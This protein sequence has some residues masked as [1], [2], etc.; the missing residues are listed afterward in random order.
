MVEKP[1]GKD[2]STFNELQREISKYFTE[3]ETYRIDHY[4]GKEMVQNIQVLR[5]A[6]AVFEPLWNKH[7]I[8]TIQ[9]TFKENIGTEGR[10]G[11][12]E[13]TGVIRDV[14]QNHLLQVLSLVAMEPPITLRADDVRDEKLRLLK[15]IAPVMPQ[16][17]VLG[18]YT[19]NA[20]GT[21]PGYTDEEGI[22]KDSNTA[23]YAA[24]VMRINNPRWKGVPFIIR[25]GKALNEKKAEIRIQF[26]A[27]P[28]S[29]FNWGTGLTGVPSTHA[30]LASCHSAPGT[31]GSLVEQAAGTVAHSEENA[32]QAALTEAQGEYPTQVMSAE[33]T[34][35]CHVLERPILG[36]GQNPPF[37]EYEG[38]TADK[39]RSPAAELG[40]SPY[41]L[42]LE[43]MKRESYYNEPDASAIYPPRAHQNELVIRIGPS[44]EVYLRF[45]SRMPGLNFIPIETELNLS[46]KSRFSNARVPE[47]YSRLLLDVFKGDQSQYVST[48]PCLLYSPKLRLHILSPFSLFVLLHSLL[49]PHSFSCRFV[50]ADELNAAWAIF[51]PLLDLLES[52]ATATARK[53]ETDSK[54]PIRDMFLSKRYPNVK[55]PLYKYPFGSR[56][57][58]EADKLVAREG[59]VYEGS[60]ASSWAATYNT[61]D[62]SIRL[63]E[64]MRSIRS[65]FVLSQNKI[66]RLMEAFVEEMRIG[67]SGD[68]HKGDLKMIPSYVTRLPTGEEQGTVWAIDLGGTNL[69]VLEV[70][71]E[72]K[73]VCRNGREFKSVL[74][75][76][77]LR[78]QGEQLFDHIAQAC[79][80]AGVPESAPIGF[81][82]SFPYAQTALNRGVLIEWTKG[83]ANPGVVG[84]DVVQMLRD[85]FVRLK[86]PDYVA[87]IVAIA[88]DT[89]GT[90]A[91]KAY[92][93][94]SCILGVILGTGTN[95]AYMEVDQMIKKSKG[96]EPS[97]SG[98]MAINMEWG[99]FGSSIR[100]DTESLP[101][102]DVDNELDANSVHP[103]KQ[104]YEKLIGGYYLGEIARLLLASLKKKGLAFESNV[105]ARTDVGIFAPYRLASK[106]LTQMITDHSTDLSVCGDI[107][108]NVLH[109]PEPTLQE[110]EIAKE[111]ARLVGYRAAVLAAIG[112]AGVLTHCERA[113]P[114]LFERTVTVG[115]DGAVF[116]HFPKFKENMLDT[117]SNLDIKN[118]NLARSSD[119]SGRGVALI[120]MVAN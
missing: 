84:N 62:R 4:L 75:P 89:V 94:P 101:F 20:A 45:M 70:H 21:K 105:A 57:P 31:R 110:K 29:L 56:G 113:T 107:L 52:Q 12:F 82:F 93:E 6:N 92:E 7:H 96:R 61:E 55:I 34:K 106:H 87:N 26:K 65:S 108:K 66:Q 90:L 35:Q 51:T 28:N 16:D 23:T 97:T 59:Y 53:P 69:R 116:E 14:V 10:A 120:A 49:S 58:P 47:A 68:N 77:L 41:G 37:L 114:D 88:N 17:V 103:G 32:S 111:I 42:G 104:R 22:S 102:H 100:S 115:I 98:H 80:D 71:L 54:L 25:A 64:M 91:A 85:A 67:L 1:F 30:S 60:Y 74:P 13:G 112:I 3:K 73:G 78:A 48:E 43:G 9:I 11:F 83:F 2:L 19:A 38:F 40:G 5:F 72:G 79:L 18:Q 39:V 99:A 86:G 109:I 24:I 50:R 95:A 33:E 15:T 27:P 119:G 81:T 118:V 44:E 8:S 76:Q 46:Y 117:L 36:V 63:E